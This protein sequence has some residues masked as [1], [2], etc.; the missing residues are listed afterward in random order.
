[1]AVEAGKR[2]ESVRRVGVMAVRVLTGDCRVVLPTLLAQSVQSVVTSPPYFGLRSYLPDGHSDKALEMGAEP[3]PDAYVNGLVEVFR[4]VWRVLRDDGT[5]W[6][7]LGDSY[8]STAPGTLGDKL[9]QR[10]ILAGVS[11]RRAEGSRKFRP[12]TPTGLKPKDLMMIPARVALALQADGWWLR[13]DII[14][15]KPNP[16]PESVTDRPTSSHEHVFLLTK[17]ERYFYDSDAVREQGSDHPVTAAR[18]GRADKGIV[19]AAALHGTGWG[20]SGNGGFER[21]PETTRNLR[22]VWTIATQPNRLGHFA[23]MPAKL[24]ERCIKAGSRGGDTILDPF[25][26]AGTAGLVADRLGRNA[27]MIELH[28]DHTDMSGER[29]HRDA[30]LFAVVERG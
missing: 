30:G 17:A 20:Q 9:N 14:W 24:A 23:M 16:M 2:R 13:S 28:P 5:L 25:A 3:T 7:N 29:I 15:A 1:M 11:D 6:L 18:N 8:C 21:A 4:E 22:N 12:D 10:G 26:G 19:G 27:V